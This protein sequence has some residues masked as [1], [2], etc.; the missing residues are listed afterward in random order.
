MERGS[1]ASSE[2]VRAMTK[3]VA[4]TIMAI[5]AACGQ[6]PGAAQPGAAVP[7]AERPI[8]TISETIA[9]LTSDERDEL[10]R[11]MELPSTYDPETRAARE[12]YLSW[13]RDRACRAASGS[14]TV[15]V[16]GIGLVPAHEANT[17]LV[18]PGCDR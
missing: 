9:T 10:L 15:F 16:P 8:T 1:L 6:P 7:S 17:Y 2:E 5:L 18:Q 12:A 11:S 3:A 13:L 4:I 14:D